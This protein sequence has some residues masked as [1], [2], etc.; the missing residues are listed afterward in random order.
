MVKLQRQFGKKNDIVV[1][2]RDIGTVVFPRAYK[3]FYLDA[4]FKERIR[5][6]MGDFKL[7]G[8]KICLKEVEDDLKKRDQA[9]MTRKV[10]PL[11]QAKDAI[12]IDT[13]NISIEQV[14]DKVLSYIK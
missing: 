5:R 9:D 6:R 13:T 12:Y 14:I 8:Q 4:E 1:E 2:G 10:G 7:L 3:K 11:K